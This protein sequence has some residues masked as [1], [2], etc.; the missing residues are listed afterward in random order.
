MAKVKLRVELNK[1]RRGIMLGKLAKIAEETLRFLSMVHRDSELSGAPEGWLAVNFDNN[2]VDFDCE[3][4]QDVEPDEA[5]RANRVLQSVMTNDRTSE[6]AKHHIRDTTRRQ[7]SRIAS[8]IDPDEKVTFKVFKNGETEPSEAHDLTR[9]FAYEI[10]LQL[11]S[12]ASYFGEIQGIIHAF[13]RTDK[14]RRLVVRDLASEKLVDCTF[15]D[16]LYVKA[17]EIMMDPNGVVFIEGDV[18]EN[19]A[20]GCIESI[21][22]KRFKLA[23]AFDESKFESL[24]GS[25][26][27]LTGLFTTEE[28]VERFRANAEHA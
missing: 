1:G 10:D 2:S 3:N 26:P 18:F 27:N 8:A 15:D 13:Y 9:T 14:P 20:T 4:L 21:K 22:A 12:S 11:P 25:A 24:I 7:Y 17:I 19:L 16:E 28:F 23:P 5:H 6:L